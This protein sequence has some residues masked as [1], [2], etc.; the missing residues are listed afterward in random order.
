LVGVRVWVRVTVTDGVGVLVG[1]GV[2]DGINLSSAHTSSIISV[3]AGFVLLT[4][5][6]IFAST[7]ARVVISV[8]FAPANTILKNTL[9]EPGNLCLKNLST[10]SIY[11]KVDVST[12]HKIS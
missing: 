8:I 2:G 4:K 7:A 6:L 1:V 11:C 3:Y 12:F 9:F 5:D 10:L